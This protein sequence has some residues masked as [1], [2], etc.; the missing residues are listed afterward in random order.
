MAA[1]VRL[2]AGRSPGSFRHGRNCALHPD[3]IAG[4]KIL[5][6]SGVERDHS[7]LPIAGLFGP[8]NSRHSFERDTGE[9]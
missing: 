2:V 1:A 5:D 3:E 4:A 6:A 9:K 8:E 7:L